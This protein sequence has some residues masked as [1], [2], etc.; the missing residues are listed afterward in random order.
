MV[1]VVVVVVVVS[2]V[3][4]RG[5]LDA[6]VHRGKLGGEGGGRKD[7]HLAGSVA[8]GVA[9]AG[10]LVEGED[11]LLVRRDVAAHVEALHGCGG[12]CLSIDAFEL[13][14]AMDNRASWALKFHAAKECIKALYMP[15]L[16]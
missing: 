5:G 2:D 9:F 14:K 10:G 13:C 4:K 12:G 3:R 8:E 6:R 15:L 16:G 1:S 7:G 11:A